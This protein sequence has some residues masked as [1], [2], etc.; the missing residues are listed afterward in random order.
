V[1]S[2]HELASNLT[3]APMAPK[4]KKPSAAANPSTD[5]ATKE[6]G[7]IPTTTN[8]EEQQSEEQEALRAIYGEEDYE[9]VETKSAWSKHS[10]RAF[11]LRLRKVLPSDEEVSLV[12]FVKLTATYPKTLPTI[13]LESP[14]GIRNKT[15]KAI[16]KLLK[17]KPKELIGEVMIYDIATAIQDILEDE[18]SFKEKGQALPS[19]EEERVV[20]EAEITKLAK[21]QEEQDLK[22]KQEEKAEEDRVLQQMVETEM[23][24]RREMKRK[25]RLTTVTSFQGEENFRL[26][27]RAL[28]KLEDLGV[29]KI[30]SNTCRWDIWSSRKPANVFQTQPRNNA[31]CLLTELSRIKMMV[32]VLNSVP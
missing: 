27:R 23:Q 16:E 26:I 20:Q 21:K 8:Y 1:L 31:I 9:E 17:S 14:N 10:D 7:T 6:D 11:R 32:L 15:Q 2:L 29:M 19:L 25:S 28:K 5:N 24:K 30:R 3:I 18:A 13:T 12:L 4:S 22:K